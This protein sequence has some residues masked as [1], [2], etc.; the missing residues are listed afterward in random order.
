MATLWC[1]EEEA[2][3]WI[4]EPE[5]PPAP[6]RVIEITAQ[7]R[8]KDEADRMERERAHRSAVTWQRP[9]SAHAKP[10]ER[11]MGYAFPAGRS[12]GKRRSEKRKA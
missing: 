3:R 9:E 1:F 6:C 8:A 12:N 10:P 4:E 11:S 5:H 7:V 2:P